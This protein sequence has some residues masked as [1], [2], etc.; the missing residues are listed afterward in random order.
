M[1]DE[2]PV[3]HGARRLRATVDPANAASIGLLHKLGFVRRDEPEEL[4]D[5]CFCRGA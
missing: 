5:W 3:A 1:L 4:P 2:L